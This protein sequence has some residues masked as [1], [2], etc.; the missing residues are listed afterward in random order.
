MTTRGI[1]VKTAAGLAVAAAGALAVRAWLDA[2][3]REQVA[4]ACEEAVVTPQNDDGVLAND[5]LAKV[6]AL[7]ADANHFFGQQDYRGAL[8]RYQ[9]ALD[10]LAKFS[11]LPSGSEAAAQQHICLANVVV[12][13]NKLGA[14]DRAAAAASTLIA[15]G[16]AVDRALL[17][18]THFRRA[19]AHEAM[20]RRAPQISDLEAAVA[21]SRAIGD[22]ASLGHAEEALVRAKRR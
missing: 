12:V 4:R 21:L 16:A 9:Q 2:R 19:T 13:L 1:V 8:Q 10:V 17:A 14:H 7:K 11:P 3:R 6:A 18:K 22:T 20:G 15:Q 5:L